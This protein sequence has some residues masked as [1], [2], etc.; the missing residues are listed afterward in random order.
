MKDEEDESTKECLSNIGPRKYTM[1]EMQIFFDQIGNVV[2][3]VDLGLGSACFAVNEIEAKV[4]I[5]K[6]EK[7]IKR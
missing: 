1:D 2:F 6:I 3:M 5:E 4:P 7:F